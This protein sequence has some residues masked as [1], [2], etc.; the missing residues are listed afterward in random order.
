MPEQQPRKTARQDDVELEAPFGWKV[1]ASGK[2]VSALV[3]ACGAV[4]ALAYMIRDHDLKEAAT[5]ATSSV[6]RR[7]QLNKITTQ[8]AQ[9][10]DSMDAVVYVLS[11]PQEQR[12]Q[13][14]LDMP[15]SMRR[16]LL[17]QERNR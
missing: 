4:G 8:Q 5:L 17:N 9:L 1:R 3:I 11:L 6:E 7:E 13:L 12:N 14:K 10:Q 16:K 2:T 15:E